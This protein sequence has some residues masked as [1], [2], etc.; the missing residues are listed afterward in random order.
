MA[1]TFDVAQTIYGAIKDT[2]ASGKRILVV[3]NL[4]NAAEATAAELLHRVLMSASGSG[5][6]GTSREMVLLD[7]DERVVKPQMKMLGKALRGSEGCP[8]GRNEGQQ[9]GDQSHCKRT[10]GRALCQWERK[11]TET[12]LM[13]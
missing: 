1:K 4:V 7:I 11:K 8:I 10:V 12:K 5:G 13:E 6:V 9:N 2:W 3:S